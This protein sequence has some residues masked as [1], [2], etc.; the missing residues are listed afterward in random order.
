MAAV[1]EG[2]NGAGIYW[3]NDTSDEDQSVVFVPGVSK[4]M[5]LKS[6]TV[7]TNEGKIKGRAVLDGERKSGTKLHLPVSRPPAD[8][9]VPTDLLQK[10]TAFS[11]K[12]KTPAILTELPGPQAPSYT[13]QAKSKASLKDLCPEDKRRIANLIEELARVS[14]EKEES[15]QRLRDE[16]ETFE[17]KI[18]QLEQQNRLIGQ[19]RES[20]QQQYR[21][22]QEL[23]GLY[24]QY[25]SQQQEKL[26]KSIAQLNQ[27]RSQSKMG[28]GEKAL[29]RPRSGGGMGAALDGSYLDL[30][31]S[32]SKAG[33]GG[34]AGRVHAFSGGFC[35]DPPSVPSSRCER[36]CSV[37]DG[38]TVGASKCPEVAWSESGPDR[39]SKREQLVNTAVGSRCATEPRGSCHGLRVENR[40]RASVELSGTVTPLGREDWTEKRQRLL[41]QKKQ[42]EL[43]RERLQAQ[44]AQQ[45]ERLLKQNQ[46]L[47]QSR[48]NYSKFQQAAA[49][50]L[51]QSFNGIRL[52]PDPQSNSPVDPHSERN[53]GG[54]QALQGSV[55]QPLNDA[56][57]Q[58]C[59]GNIQPPVPV[60]SRELPA[61]TKKDMA[62]SPVH[63]Q[64]FQKPE[65]PLALPL[66]IPKTPQAS[67]LDSSLIELLDIFSPVANP[68]RSRVS[69]DVH[70]N[71]TGPRKPLGAVGPPHS[72]LLSPPGRTQPTRQ[73][74]EESQILEDIFFIC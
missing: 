2:R 18:Q 13:S 12:P 62:T 17:K 54:L 67:R 63:S 46:E 6:V 25:L 58:K 70:G 35:S 19:E 52:N 30:P 55:R 59:N 41:H 39:L 31:S 3:I 72:S 40:N 22:C 47:R 34:S 38:G 73:D 29:S 64:S 8:K 43:E 65:S 50:E 21:E 23:L 26:N 7:S 36:D 11:A 28:S 71:F 33:R 74:L 24:Q 14:E 5:G 45:E 10:S 66:N 57:P 49:T 53:E 48:L 44:L 69:P 68:K 37:R 61:G 32:G 15:V 1:T 27:S 20:L 42:L 9:T 60:P 51:E 56:H 4:K 16:Q